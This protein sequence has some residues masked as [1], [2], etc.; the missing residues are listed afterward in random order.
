[1]FNLRLVTEGIEDESTIAL[2]CELGCRI[3]Q[4]YALA[5][6]MESADFMSSAVLAPAPEAN[7]PPPSPSP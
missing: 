2:L 5:R 6:P 7:P 4:G 3:G 1:M